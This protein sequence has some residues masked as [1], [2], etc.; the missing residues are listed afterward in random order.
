[1]G[2]KSD[3]TIR[4]D[5]EGSAKVK[6]DYADIAAAS[7]QSSARTIKAID[8]A[9]KAAEDAEARKAALRAQGDAL[10]T[11]PGESPASPAAQQATPAPNIGSMIDQRRAQAAAQALRDQLDPAAKAQRGFNAEVATARELLEKGVISQVEYDGAVGLAEKALKSASTALKEH[12]TALGL[13]RAQYITAQ[14]AVLRFSDMVM[15]G[16]SPLRAFALE[17]HKGAEVLSMDEGGMAGG[18]AKVRGLFT[19]VTIGA[20]G[21]TAAIVAGAAAAYSYAEQLDRMSRM[22]DGFGRTSLLTGGQLQDLARTNDGIGQLT[23]KDAEEVESAILHQTRTSAEALGQAITITQRFA[24]AMG[25][26]AKKA[27]EDLGKAMADPAKGADDLASKYGYLSQAQVEQIHQLMEQNRLTD[28]QRALLG[29]LGG[30]L[31]AAGEHV[32]MLTRAWRGLMAAMSQGWNDVGAAINHAMGNFTNAE[33]TSALQAKIA[34]DMRTLQNPGDIPNANRP[35]ERRALIEARLRQNQTE[36]AKLAGGEQQKNQ[37]I[38]AARL[39]AETR[40]TVAKYGL[41]TNVSPKLESLKQELATAEQAMRAGVK[42]DGNTVDALRHA[43]RTFMTP[44]QQR[45]AIQTA[46]ADLRRAAPHSRER[47]LAGQRLKDAQTSGQ[48]ITEA[49]AN[50]LAQE[51]GLAA[52]GHGKS[53]ASGEKH[54][55]TLAREAA[56]MDVAAKASLSLADAYLDS[57]AAAL[58][59]EAYRKAA[60]D[61]TKKGIDIDAQAARQLN[62]MV[63]EQVANTA[64]TIRSSEDETAARKQVLAAVEAGTI[65]ARDMETQLTRENALRPL[66]AL[67]TIAHG[68]ALTKLTAEIER[69]KQAMGQAQAADMKWAAQQGIN[70]ANDNARADRLR[71]RLAAIRDPAERA[72]LSA[73]DQGDA[74]GWSTGDSIR[75]ADAATAGAKAKQAADSAEWLANAQHQ[76]E[77]QQTLLDLQMRYAS[78]KDQDD[79]AE[80]RRQQLLI[81]LDQ[82]HL[83]LSDEQITAELA[84][85]KSLKDLT[86]E[87]GRQKAGW[88][89]LRDDGANA[90]D[91]L[92]NPDN[93]NNWGATFHSVLRSILM[94]FEKLA[95]LNPLENAIFG[96]NRATLG[97][98]GGGGGLLGSLF[99]GLFGGGADMSGALGTATA[100]ANIFADLIPKAILPGFAT[101]TNGA[102]GGMALV[103]EYGPEIVNLPRGAG[104]M[105][106]SES[107]SA[108]SSGGGGNT[109]HMPITIN[110]QGA[111]PREVDVLRAEIINLRRSIPSMAVQ[112]TNDAVARRI[113]RAA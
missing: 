47:E 72:R 57:G 106:A 5:T 85:R 34:A 13:N 29:D 80:I 43:V 8:R 53:G 21:L 42:V 88:Q 68:A 16:Q 61:A 59:A 32:N 2:S 14:S 45:I 60:T 92:L 49:G 64:K 109:F 103:G 113:G 112:A 74:K 52:L 55:E 22:A 95:L 10:F 37:S 9:A 26:D 41:D 108:L 104:V 91:Q 79:T 71:E 83:A 87:V 33:K 62:L 78:T 107:R 11:R 23:V 28:A 77:M 4:L 38:E 102:P 48:V 18:L 76:G 31:D 6:N 44:E 46:Q 65:P 86:D 100:N 15:A 54:A 84:R 30:S 39:A 67:Q 24:D 89:Q 19:P 66:L 12:G 90:L 17:A 99:G 82:Q 105:T 58:K 101:G 20:I 63:A 50:A 69:Y 96:G 27:A 94:D 110:A 70:A 3:Y 7:E 75:S 98:G 25:I 81:E 35:D 97:G 93:L 111:G 40:A 36:Y 73:L 56:S 51:R 1:M